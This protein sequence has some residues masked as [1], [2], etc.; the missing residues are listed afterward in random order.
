MH[1]STSICNMV[2]VQEGMAALLSVCMPRQ[3]LSAASHDHAHLAMLAH[4]FESFCIQ[5]MVEQ[6][7][8]HSFQSRRVL[9]RLN[10]PS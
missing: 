8:N 6:N 4:I 1:N 9:D 5:Q 10:R 3:A 2:Q 7:F